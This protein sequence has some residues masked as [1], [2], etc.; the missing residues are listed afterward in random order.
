MAETGLNFS[1]LAKGRPRGFKRS[2]AFACGLIVLTFTWLLSACAGTA[3]GKRSSVYSHDQTLSLVD[4]SESTADAMVII[5][6]PAVLDEDAVGAYYRAFEQNV[7]GSPYKSN[8]QTR[9]DS[10][11]IAQSIIAKS[12]YFAMSLYREL[13]QEL[14]E[15]S[16]LLS[17]HLVMLDGDDRLSSRPLLASEDIP[18]VVII[19]FNVY[20]HPDPR[21]MMDSE[22]LT[23]GDIVTPL[24]VVHANHWLKPST[25]GLLL[26]SNPLLNSAWEQ[27]GS[28]L[29][30]QVNSR[31]EDAITEYHEPLDFISFLQY[32][33]HQN[34]GV[35]LKSGGPARRDVIAVEQYP[36]EKIRMD[37]EVVAALASD[38]SVDPFAE[39][40]VK[41][42]STR[43]VTALNNIDHDRATFFSRQQSLARFDPELAI[44]FL[45]RSRDESVRARLRM[46]DTLLV[47][48][49]K[50]LSSQSDSLYEGTYEGIYGDQ[51]RQMIAA[52]YRLLEE[53]RRLARTQNINTALAVL[54]A[55]GSVYVGSNS[56]SSNFFQSRTLSNV[57]LLSSVWAMNT[58]MAA[59]VESK[60]IGQNFLMQ[61][62]PAINRQVSVQVEWLQSSEV[63]T[64]GDFSEFRAKT[65]ALYQNSVRS[66][67]HGFDQRCKFSHPDLA[68]PGRWYGRCFGGLASGNGY[69]L[70]LN[71][72]GASVEYLGSADSGLAS[73]T[74]AMIFQPLEEAGVVYYEGDFREG[75][76]DGVVR[77]EEPGRKPRVRE[78][79]AGSDQGA[80]EEDRLQRLQF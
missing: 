8:P 64:A 59:N 24:F 41:G 20:S 65:L 68:T 79:H 32:G 67:D 5:R 50:F 10:D 21:K 16:V 69:G 71:G 11:Q 37:G 80:A 63:I 54:A 48:E 62:A 2:R 49:R 60:T 56:N 55:V 27:S 46:A 26:S 75:L 78:F 14:P 15:N 30:E 25:R 35:P 4:N 40:F 28:Q 44:A 19:D 17:P 33:W 61:M 1:E 58:A 39:D 77:I 22:P 57:M 52:E 45:T 34:S 31:L 18:S 3:T 38:H 6:Y 42:A 66:L 74:G 29:E 9:R 73:G 51:M 7:I 43:I 23:F 13:Q 12:N 72:D 47:A 53:R 36:V 76:P 70:I